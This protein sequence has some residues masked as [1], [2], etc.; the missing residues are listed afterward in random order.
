MSANPVPTAV[1]V[2]EVPKACEEVT[3]RDR[4]AAAD[5]VPRDVDFLQLLQRSQRVGE[6]LH[7]VVRQLRLR[8]GLCFFYFFSN[9]WLFFLANFEKPVFGCIDTDFCKKICVLQH[10]SKST[11]SSS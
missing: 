3:E 5:L 7:P 10:F 9:F 6:L 4:S 8:Q 11:R 2:L 1:Q